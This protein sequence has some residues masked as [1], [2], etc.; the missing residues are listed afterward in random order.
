MIFKGFACQQANSITAQGI[1]DS[2][3]KKRIISSALKTNVSSILK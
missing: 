2:T 3:N 1:T